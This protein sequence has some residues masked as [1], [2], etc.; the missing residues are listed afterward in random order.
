M[1]KR[2]SRGRAG[3]PSPDKHHGRA[4]AKKHSNAGR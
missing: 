4:I 3:Q 1:G 2:P